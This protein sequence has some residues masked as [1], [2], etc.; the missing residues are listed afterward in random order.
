M[1]SPEEQ[2]RKAVEVAFAPLKCVATI[3]ATGDRLSFQV[4]SDNN[5]VLRMDLVAAQ[6]LDERQRTKI[7]GHALRSLIARGLLRVGENSD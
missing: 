1:D 7:V 6:F 4:Y 5:P 2:A 3:S